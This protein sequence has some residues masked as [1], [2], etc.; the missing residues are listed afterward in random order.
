MNNLNVSEVNALKDLL[1][2]RIL[3]LLFAWTDNMN[4][5]LFLF[6]VV[7]DLRFEL[8]QSF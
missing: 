7:D 5:I 1:A 8:I 3:D 6:D 4:L 2:M